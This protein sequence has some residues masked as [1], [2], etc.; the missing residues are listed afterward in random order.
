MGRGGSAHNNH[1]NNSH[2][3]SADSVPMENLSLY[4]SGGGGGRMYPP[5]QHMVRPGEPVYAQVNRDKK[6]VRGGAGDGGGW[7]GADYS[8]HALH[9]SQQQ[10]QGQA[11]PQGQQGSHEQQAGGEGGRGTQQTAGQA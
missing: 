9:W 11:G 7:D 6:R 1:A 2:N 5:G 8:E 10:Q 3:Y 4:S